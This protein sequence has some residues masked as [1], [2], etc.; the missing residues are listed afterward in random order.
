MTE[1][2]TVEKKNGIINS[3]R[4]LDEAVIGIHRTFEPGD[5]PPLEVTREFFEALTRGS[6]DDSITYGKPGIRIYVA[7]TKEATDA[8]ESMNAEEFH[9]REIAKRQA[10]N[11]AKRK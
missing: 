7:G 5:E 8:V 4:E 6:Q 1:K 3:Y 2:T 9:N 11:K 10:A